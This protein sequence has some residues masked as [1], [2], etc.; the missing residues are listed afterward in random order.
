MNDRSRFR[1]FFGRFLV[2]SALGGFLLYS[3]YLALVYYPALA[4]QKESNP[5]FVDPAAN[6]A[7]FLLSA[8]LYGPIFG[9]FGGLLS[10]GFRALSVKFGGWFLLEVGC[11]AAGTSI[12]LTIGYFLLISNDGVS[13]PLWFLVLAPIFGVLFD[14]AFIVWARNRREV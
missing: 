9:I 7:L 10:I 6:L 14:V 5:Q 8:I 13:S 3:G 4:A 2:F 11:V 12:A 1:W